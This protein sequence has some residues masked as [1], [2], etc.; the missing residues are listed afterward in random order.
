MF[1]LQRGDALLSAQ[2]GEQVVAEG[3]SHM[4]GPVGV[5]ALSGDVGLDGKAQDGD[6]GQA[7]VLDLLDLELLQDL[8]VVG[9]AEGVEGSSGVE[10]VDAGEDVLVELAD[11]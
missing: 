10:G 3:V 6:H 7:A 9:Q 5:G 2:H 11:T 4:L 1:R 8:G